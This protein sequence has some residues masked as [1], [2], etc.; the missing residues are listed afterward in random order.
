MAIISQTTA[1][2]A[3]LFSSTIENQLLHGFASQQ[4]ITGTLC[5][6]IRLNLG[7]ISLTFLQIISTTKILIPYTLTL[8][9]P[10]KLPCFLTEEL[11]SHLVDQHTHLGFFS[12]YMCIFYIWVPFSPFVSR[13]SREVT[14]P[15]YL[16]IATLHCL[17]ESLEVLLYIL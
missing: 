12:S 11:L 4:P 6:R 9:L 16:E 10:Y 7:H 5:G 15:Q 13:G 3:I 2:I 17:P 1:L 8:S 14:C